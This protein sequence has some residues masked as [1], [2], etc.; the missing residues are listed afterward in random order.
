M[1][2]YEL[3][4]CN[5]QI[6]DATLW[7]RKRDN[8]RAS[9]CSATHAHYEKVED[10]KSNFSPH[11]STFHYLQCRVTGKEGFH[12]DRRNVMA[13]IT[14]EIP[15]KRLRKCEESFGATVGI[16]YRDAAKSVSTSDTKGA[17]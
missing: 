4:G 10:K 11:A 13:F 7:M 9:D 17:N 5:L 15:S 6:S 3:L 8:D 12:N 16:N 2:I 1:C 14:C